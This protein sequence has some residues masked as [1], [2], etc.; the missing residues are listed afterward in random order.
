MKTYL[1][2]AFCLFALFSMAQAP[3]DLPPNAEPG[4][5][6][7]KCLI[8][9][10]F[11]IS[12]FEVAVYSGTPEDKTVKRK[13]KKIILAEG[14]TEWVKKKSDRKCLSGDPNDCL[15]WCLVETPE[16]SVEREVVLDLSKTDAYVMETFEKKELKK[17]GGFTEW[18]EIIC[19]NKVNSN[20]IR[21]IQNA[22]LSE[23]FLEEL[24]RKAKF[25][26]KT[27][28]ALQSFQRENDL[29]IG[30]LDFE[31]MDALNIPY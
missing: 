8:G 23:G 24:P 6:F 2:L 5:C 11:R 19:A 20:L 9:D 22:L 26:S 30:N 4:K 21:Q 29:P 1:T 25:K 14:K 10:D 27:K 7:A 3:G 16:V 13:T 15:V 18:K 17:K 12:T 28:Q 31:T